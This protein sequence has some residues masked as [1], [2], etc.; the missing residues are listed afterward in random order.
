MRM[1]KDE[2]GPYRVFHLNRPVIMFSE[3]D[4]A[5]EYVAA[6]PSPGD[7]EILDKSDES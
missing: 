5:L 4:A 2:R 6:Q 7:W 1:S 3:R